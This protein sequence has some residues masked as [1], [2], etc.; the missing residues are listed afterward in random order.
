[1]LSLRK[2]QFK[3]VCKDNNGSITTKTAKKI[4]HKDDYLSAH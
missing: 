3:T 1:M 2:L 4:N